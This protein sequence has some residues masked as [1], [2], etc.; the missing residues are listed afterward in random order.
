MTSTSLSLRGASSGHCKPIIWVLR[1]K[2]SEG[3]NDSDSGESARRKVEK[4]SSNEGSATGSELNLLVQGGERE[5]LEG[6]AVGVTCSAKVATHL[7]LAYCDADTKFTLCCN[8]FGAHIS[9]CRQ[10]F[11]PANFY[12]LDLPLSRVHM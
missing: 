10:V 9:H 6:C 5:G 11:V 2:D 7:S 8:N 4:L 12:R 1:I 3:L